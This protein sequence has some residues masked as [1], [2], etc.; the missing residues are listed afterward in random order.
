[1]DYKL[2]YTLDNTRYELVYDYI[3]DAR[4]WRAK[5]IELGGKD[6]RLIVQKHV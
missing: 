4:E 3:D 6:V 1:M 2:T 5:I